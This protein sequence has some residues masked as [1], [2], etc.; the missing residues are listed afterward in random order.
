MREARE[1]M[2]SSDSEKCLTFHAFRGKFVLWPMH[3][4]LGA[5]ESSY[6]FYALRRRQVE[7]IAI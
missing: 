1:K 6:N 5:E 2:S 3:G 4:L 7:S